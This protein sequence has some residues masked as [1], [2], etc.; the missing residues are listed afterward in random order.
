MCGLRAEEIMGV[1]NREP[2]EDS[3]YESLVTCGPAAEMSRA[4][5]GCYRDENRKHA[6]DCQCGRMRDCVGTSVVNRDK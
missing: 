4:R 6:I 5:V 1:L 2:V 3:T